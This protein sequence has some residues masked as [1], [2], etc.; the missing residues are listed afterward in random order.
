MSDYPGLSASRIL[1]RV[2]GR[3]F[4]NASPTSLRLGVG[5]LLG[6]GVLSGGLFNAAGHWGSKADD[7]KIAAQNQPFLDKERQEDQIRALKD[8]NERLSVTP[9]PGEFKTTIFPEGVPPGL[10]NLA[11]LVTSREAL[12]LA[13]PKAHH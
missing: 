1:T 2:A 12:G 4:V 13:A 9:P 5:L 10:H 7:A 3:N 8:L 11:V 6:Y